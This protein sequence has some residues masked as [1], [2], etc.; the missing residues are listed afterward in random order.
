MTPVEIELEGSMTY[1]AKDRHV[2]YELALE[3]VGGFL[4]EMKSIVSHLLDLTYANDACRTPAD[5]STQSL[6]VHFNPN[7]MTIS[8]FHFAEKRCQTN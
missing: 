6:N 2:D 1:N 4:A 8:K 3:V 5:Q 7:T